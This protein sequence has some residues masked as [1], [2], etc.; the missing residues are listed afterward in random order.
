MSRV[1]TQLQQVVEKTHK[2][3]FEQYQIMPVKTDRG[4][5][6]GRVL[7]VT[8]HAVKDLY[9]SNELVYSNVC[10]N[11]VTIMLANLLAKH[12][13]THA[14]DKLYRADA[15]YGKWQQESQF[16]RTKYQNAR[17]TGNNDK[18]DIYLARYCTARDRAKYYHEYVLTLLII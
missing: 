14:S 11:T 8:N 5:L 2:R 9:L 3:L 10:L 4:I 1:N 17:K 6:V 13:T 15:D 7:I 18:A 12:G 16:L